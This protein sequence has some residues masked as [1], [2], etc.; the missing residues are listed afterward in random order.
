MRVPAARPLVSL[1]GFGPACQK[2]DLCYGTCK[3]DKSTCD[4]AFEAGMKKACKG[5]R[6]KERAACNDIADDYR[7]AVTL[8]AGGNYDD[9]QREVCD[10]CP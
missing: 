9:A 3:S 2:H 1:N 10:C 7:T 6:G 5:A 8:L 4:D